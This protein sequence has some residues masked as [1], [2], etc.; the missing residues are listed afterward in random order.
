MLGS[1]SPLSTVSSSLRLCDLTLLC[2]TWWIHRRVERI[3]L[4][5]CHI[6]IVM[7]PVKAA[8]AQHPCQCICLMSS[9]NITLQLE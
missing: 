3:R 7:Y 4:N 9:Q 5:F 1:A 2:P 8:K 6:T